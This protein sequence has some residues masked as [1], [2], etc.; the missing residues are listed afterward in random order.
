MWKNRPFSGINSAIFKARMLLNQIRFGKIGLAL[1][2]AGA[3]AVSARADGTDIIMT[4][5]GLGSTTSNVSGAS[6][7]SFDNLPLTVQSNVPWTGIGT[8]SSL[9]IVGADQYGG[10]ADAAFPN[11]HLTR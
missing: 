6:L 10:A 5:G 4:Y 1:C 11:A 8:F 2:V 9:S 3:T 7:F